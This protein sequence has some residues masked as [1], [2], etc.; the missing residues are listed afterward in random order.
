MEIPVTHVTPNPVGYITVFFD[1][2]SIVADGMGDRVISGNVDISF[3]GGNTWEALIAAGDWFTGG[4]PGPRAGPPPYISNIGI[5]L[6]QPGNNL[7]RIRGN[8]TLSHAM[9]IGVTTEFVNYN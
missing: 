7:R 6:K 5:E 1:I 2:T 3:D 8:F 4:P 9:T